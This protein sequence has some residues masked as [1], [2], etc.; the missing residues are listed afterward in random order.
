MV[1]DI[2]SNRPWRRINAFMP[3]TNRIVPQQGH[4]VG[5]SGNYNGLGLILR[6]YIFDH[7]VIFS[8]VSIGTASGDVKLH[9]AN[10]Y[11]YIYI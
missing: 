3:T 9:I 5:T 2:H 7:R 6:S 11:I 10:I 4:A 8:R 1:H